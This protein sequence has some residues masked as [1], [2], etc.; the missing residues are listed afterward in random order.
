MNHSFGY[1]NSC[2]LTGAHLKI[3]LCPEGMNGLKFSS[4][5]HSDLITEVTQQTSY[6]ELYVSTQLSKTIEITINRLIFRLSQRIF[7]KVAFLLKFNFVGVKFTSLLPYPNFDRIRLLSYSRKCL[8]SWWY[9]EPIFSNFSHPLSV[10][11]M[12]IFYF[13]YSIWFTEISSL[14]PVIS[15]QGRCSYY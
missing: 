2:K 13:S 4:A 3:K 6:T 5:T 15:D 8:K 7:L 14:R 9:F 1:R 12:N 11:R 10:F